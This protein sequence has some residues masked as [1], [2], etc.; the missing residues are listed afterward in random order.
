VKAG[1][2]VRFPLEITTRTHSDHCGIWEWKIGL[3][4]RHDSEERSTLILCEG[5]VVRIHAGEIQRIDEEIWTSKV[6]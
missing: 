3:I 1:D 2:M 5:K 6:W 4:V